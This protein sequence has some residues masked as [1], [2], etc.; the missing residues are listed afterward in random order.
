LEEDHLMIPLNAELIVAAAALVAVLVL[1]TLRRRRA[2]KGADAAVAEEAPAP[3]EALVATA[4]PDAVAVDAADPADKTPAKRR[5]RGMMPS[6]RRGAKD[7]AEDAEIANDTPGDDAT[8]G[9][10]PLIPA[11]PDAVHDGAPEPAEDPMHTESETP[12]L[13]GTA[14]GAAP[15]AEPAAAEVAATAMD[16]APNGHV[17]ADEADV[18][19][20]GSASDDAPHLVD[21]E[22]PMFGSIYNHEE[23]EPDWDAMRHPAPV[24]AA[25]VAAPMMATAAPAARVTASSSATSDDEL[26]TR[27]GWPLPGD[28]EAWESADMH[29]IS[30]GHGGSPDPGHWAEAA[31]ASSDAGQGN[32]GGAPDDRHKHPADAL[33]LSIGEP[34]PAPPNVPPASLSGAIEPPT[35]M[36]GEP[37]LAPFG[38]GLDA[39]APAGAN[40]NFDPSFWE[41]NQSTEA[42]AQEPEIWPPAAPASESGQWAQPAD[43]DAGPGSADEQPVTASGGGGSPTPPDSQDWWTKPGGMPEPEADPIVPEAPVSETAHSDADW[44]GAPTA[45]AAAPSDD[46]WWVAQTAPAAEPGPVQNGYSAPAPQAPAPELAGETIPAPAPP[47][48]VSQE[49]TADSPAVVMPTPTEGVPIP[50]VPEPVA[51]TPVDAAPAAAE[52][53]AYEPPAVPYVAPEPQTPAVVL[54]AVEIPVAASPAPAAPAPPAPAVPEVELPVPT[55]SFAPSAPEPAPT[56]SAHVDSAGPA[57]VP[58]AARILPRLDAG[59]KNPPATG[60]FAVGGTAVAPGDGAFTRVRFRAPLNRPIIGWAVGDAPDY[61][62]G[63]LVLVVDAVLNC[64]ADRLTVLQ[65]DGDP[66]RPDGFTLSLSSH[67]SGPFAV[68]G[69]YHVVC[70]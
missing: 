16:V 31:A 33:P 15:E 62:P 26:I 22:L 34:Y 3:A 55:T 48:P 59:A 46:Q 21:A 68:S 49:P 56:A 65:D 63:T 36:I 40:T 14:A 39:P 64:S 6:V 5:F 13:V 29:D 10:I 28:L 35:S 52:P 37:S 32:P 19:L 43:A 42:N 8:T 25:A 69:S 27:P 47:A 7:P 66:G 57:M 18:P 67:S 11:S 45:A 60:R 1:I 23:D 53:M 9:V 2:P 54:P 38:D 4:A 58:P 17:Q 24:S 44:W 30:N 20:F 41:V 51:P 50:V 61:A 70:G 12:V